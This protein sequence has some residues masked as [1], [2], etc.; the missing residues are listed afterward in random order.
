[1]T[2]TIPTTVEVAAA[3]QRWARLAAP[4]VALLLT[5]TVLLMELAYELGHQLGQA[6]H[7][8]SDQLAR[9]WVQLVVPASDAQP[10]TPDPLRCNG[11]TPAS[12]LQPATLQC[13]GS[14]AW[15]EI[16]ASP[17]QHPLQAVATELQQLTV[18][19]LQL[20]CGT[21]RRLAK[22]ELVAMALAC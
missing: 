12:A 4:F 21:R 16:P 11:S 20:I 2:I 1:M 14:E 13:N 3:L 18:K 17:L 6:V 22:A 8:R 7:E 10:A 19:E 9:I 15:T 5:S